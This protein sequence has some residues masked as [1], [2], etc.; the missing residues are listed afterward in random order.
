MYIL[1]LVECSIN[2]NKVLLVDGSDQFYILTDFLIKRRVFISST[3]VVDV[4]VPPFSSVIFF[5][6]LGAFSFFFF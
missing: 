3:L 4:F 1:M 6:F 2:F 5:F